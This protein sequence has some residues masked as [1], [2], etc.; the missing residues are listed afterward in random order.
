MPTMNRY[1][2][3]PTRSHGNRKVTNGTRALIAVAALSILAAC[4]NPSAEPAK[5][6]RPDSTAA[7][8]QNTDQARQEAER[9][10]EPE[11]HNQKYQ[12]VAQSFA[13]RF[14]ELQKQR[15][16]AG[17]QGD[18]LSVNTSKEFYEGKLAGTNPNPDGEWIAVSRMVG[19][20]IS[21]TTKSDTTEEWDQYF[22][23]VDFEKSPDGKPDPSK[24]T[25]VEISM[26]HTT[27]HREGSGIESPY[28]DSDS[29]IY[30]YSLSLKNGNWQTDVVVREASAS[31]QF[32]KGGMDDPLDR[33]SDVSG[34]DLISAANTTLDMMVIGQEAIDPLPQFAPAK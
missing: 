18:G 10:K 29:P 34:G 8:D 14:I 31:Y 33:L 15:T 11:A 26:K 12:A 32:N 16:V 19:D 20:K 27:R 30:D 25:K 24:V 21:D 23:R 2:K 28:T 7:A 5:P 22:A 1:E 3:D 9:Q 17:P 6:V 13:E 4:S